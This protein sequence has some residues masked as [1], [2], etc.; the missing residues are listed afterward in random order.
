MGAS[1]L[2]LIFISS[3][4]DCTTFHSFNVKKK[5]QKLAGLWLAGEMVNHIGIYGSKVA[6]SLSAFQRRSCETYWS[7]MDICSIWR[8]YDFV[9]MIMYHTDGLVQERHNF[10]ALAMELH[11]SCIN[12]SI[13]TSVA[14][15]CK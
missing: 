2:K 5:I 14:C 3:T 1:N 6:E 12:P 11:F 9:Y 8:Q 10:S 4:W 15:S 13:M 7:A